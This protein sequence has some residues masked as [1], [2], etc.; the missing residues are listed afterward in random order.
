MN[1][2]DI[3]NGNDLKRDYLLNF[4]A[5]FW[6]NRIDAAVEDLE[7]SADKAVKATHLMNLYS[8]YLQSVEVF[9][10]NLFAIRKSGDSF[11]S[12]IFISNKNLQHK[13][14]KEQDKQYPE[15]RDF[16]KY[17]ILPILIEKRKNEDKAT[18][19]LHRYQVILAEIIKDYIQDFELL[20]AYKHGFR[21]KFRSEKSSVSFSVGEN[22]ELFKLADMDSTIEYLSRRTDQIRKVQTITS[23]FTSFNE[24]RVVIKARLLGY[25]LADL[26]LL[27]QH[28]LEPKTDGVTV[29][30]LEIEDMNKWRN[31]FGNFR[32]KSPI[33][34]GPIS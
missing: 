4:D 17:Y 33:L 8:L 27:C 29:F 30:L 18:E 7:K 5:E 12:A 9:F 10:I 13:I 20:N 34:Q 14:R 1:K 28:T 6:A 31:S 21:V 16:L 26:V 23:S 19:E 22:K 24:Y 3:H 32:N 11:I 15:I 25:L 2:S